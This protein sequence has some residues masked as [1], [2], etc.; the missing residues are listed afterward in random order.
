MKK[1]GTILPP[2]LTVLG[3]ALAVQ[4]LSDLGILQ[5]FVLPAPGAVLAALWQGRAELAPHAA[6]TFLL[7][8]LGFLLSLLVALVLAVAMDRLPIFHRAVYPLVV[9]SQTIPILV[10]APVIILLFG[11]GFLPRLVVVVLVCFFPV[12]ISLSE[13]FRAFDPDWH[14]LLRSMG[15]RPLAVLFHGKLPAAL[16]AFFAGTRVSA[17]YCV[18][19]AVLAEWMGADRGLG[20]YMMRVR[21]SYA[22]DRMF[23]AIL[24]IVVESLLFFALSAWIQRVSLP[25]KEKGVLTD[26]PSASE[27]SSS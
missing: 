8:L 20:A 2:V 10:L 21:R 1:A 18:M 26:A 7:S 12:C 27:P 16:P 3:L 25:W 11:F 5:G 15:A 24:L 22:Y 13:A 6:S 23:A 19:A 9:G 14:R 4:A 17:T